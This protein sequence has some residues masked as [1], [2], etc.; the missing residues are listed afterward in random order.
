M[1]R[2]EFF[3][4]HTHKGLH[5]SSSMVQYLLGVIFTFAVLAFK[6]TS[7]LFLSEI[8]WVAT[9]TFGRGFFPTFLSETIDIL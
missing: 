9:P 6:H 5:G 3:C 2:L 4:V 8:M 1:E 7:S